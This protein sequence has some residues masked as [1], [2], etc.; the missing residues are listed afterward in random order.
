M[1]KK[2]VTGLVLTSLFAMSAQSTTMTI[3]DKAGNTKTYS[4]SDIKN[5]SF[6]SNTAIHQNLNKAVLKQNFTLIRR[7]SKNI[8]QIT[9]KAESAC[10]ISVCNLNGKILFTKKAVINNAGQHQLNL[11]S[12]GSQICLVKLISNNTTNSRLINFMN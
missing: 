4:L 2:L 11:P 5:L 6:G 9:G 12:F 10:L 3:T 8:L 7:A 1:V